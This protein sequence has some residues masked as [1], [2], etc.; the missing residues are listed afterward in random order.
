MEAIKHL[1]AIVVVYNKNCGD[2]STCKALQKIHD[3][4]ISVIIYDNSTKD[5]GNAEYCKRLGWEYLGG[6]GNVGISKAYNACIEFLKGKKSTGLICLFDDDTELDPKYF[7]ML[8][9]A[10]VSS[11]KIYVPMI[12]SDERLIS[13]CILEKG[14]RVIEFKDE[15]QLL[16][17]NGDRLSAINSCMAIDL[18]VFDDYRYDENIFL[19]GV[20]HYFLCEMRDRGITPIVFPYK[21][22][23]AFSGTEHPP[24]EVVKKRFHIYKKDYS[25]ILKNDRISYIRLVGKRALSL[26]LKYK[27]LEF[28]FMR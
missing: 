10:S 4:S 1:S 7:D 17:Y 22:N 2:S 13:P 19:D 26:S 23:H 9:E 18:S 24:K 12:F 6:K 21:C 8:R 3:D 25:Y 5:F 16:N 14:H 27:T 11:A 15:N 20:D 28:L